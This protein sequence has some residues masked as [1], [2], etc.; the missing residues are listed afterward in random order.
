[1]DTSTFD[2][3]K[4]IVNFTHTNTCC[5]LGVELNAL[6]SSMLPTPL[7]STIC[8]PRTSEDG[9]TVLMVSAS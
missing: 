4:L 3:Y 8:L 5:P 7:S 1:M 6:P 9:N 2:D